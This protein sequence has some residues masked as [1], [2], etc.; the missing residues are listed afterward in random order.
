MS[1][2]ARIIINYCIA[3]DIGTLAVLYNQT[4]QRGSNLG[5]QTNQDFVSIPYGKLRGQTPGS[6]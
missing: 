5:K 2:A 3:N 6:L 4:F 1:K